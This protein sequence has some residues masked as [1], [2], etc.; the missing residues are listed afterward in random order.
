M[1]L[2]DINPTIISTDNEDDEPGEIVHRK[3]KPIKYS[4]KNPVVNIYAPYV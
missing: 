1:D 4:Y 3:R 2:T